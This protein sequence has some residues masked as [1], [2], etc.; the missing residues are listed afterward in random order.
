MNEVPAPRSRLLQLW[1]RYKHLVAIGS[2]ALGVASLVLVQR[3][4]K[5]AQ[6]LVFMLPLSWLVALFEPQWMK[7]AERGRWLRHSPIVVRYLLQGLHQESFFFTLPFF[8]A[9]T[10]WTTAQPLFLLLLAGFALVS[11]IDPLYFDR[12]VVHRGLLWTFHAAAG[13]ATML[14]AAPMLWRITTA[15]SLW[16]AI[17]AG[18]VLAVPA[19]AAVLPGRRW[20]R[21]PLAIAAAALLG[22]ALSLLRFAIPPATLTVHGALVTET[23]DAS[24]RKPGAAIHEISTADLIAHGLYAWTPIHAPRGLAEQVVHQWWHDGRLVD[25]IPIEVRGSREDGYRT[26]THKQSFPADAQGNWQIRV[27]TQSDQLIGI[28]RFKVD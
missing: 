15:T 9:T 1:S 20:L 17:G 27:V 23:V 18:C 22:G 2:F 16:L 28:V 6:T 24:A 25:S 4:T 12:V 14:T 3:Q 11:M 26:W 5:V 10:T 13:F 19:F 7:L 8:L 21:W